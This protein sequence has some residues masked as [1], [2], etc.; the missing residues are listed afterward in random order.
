MT[1]TQVGIEVFSNLYSL[2]ISFIQVN[3]Q[4]GFC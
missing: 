3:C 2:K 1:S 4:T